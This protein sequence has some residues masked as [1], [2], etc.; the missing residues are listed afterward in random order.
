LSIDAETFF[1]IR[2]TRAD[3]PG[4]AS[5]P[6]RRGTYAMALEQFE[7][8]LGAAENASPAVRPLP[9]FY[10]VSQAGRAIA[11]ADLPDAWK[12]HGHGLVCSDLSPVSV[13]ELEIAPR[14]NRDAVV[15][16]SFHGVTAATGSEAPSEPMRLGALWM[17]L[18]EV[19]KLIA[20]VPT[21]AHWAEA[22]LVL[23]NQDVMSPLWDATRVKAS[24]L[25]A[26]HP[27]G[28][29]LA[30][31]LGR[32]PNSEGVVTQRISDG[33]TAATHTPLGLALDLS[34]PAEKADMAGRQNTLDRIVPTA[35]G[36]DR[37]WRPLISGAAMNDLMMWW[38]LLFGLSMLARYE[39]AGWNEMLDLDEGPLA[40]H[41]IRLMDAAVD[42]V[43]WLVL[44]VLE[45][46][47]VAAS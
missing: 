33:S 24:V 20:D 31:E 27:L 38:A 2:R 4:R 34:W 13:L 40:S 8:L 19:C 6:E 7:E 39:P 5:E 15:P 47:Y 45:P 44:Q 17:A 3:P 37:W 12:L 10:A 14:P 43:P 32:Y 22:L 29:S 23:P 28:V 21:V 9:L 25:G 30:Q 26:R 35:P 41:L 42:V 36:G 16:D 11:A 18:P 1:F 46:G